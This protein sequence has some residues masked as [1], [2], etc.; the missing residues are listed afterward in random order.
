MQRK[1]G[2]INDNEKSPGG[3]H[4]GLA[5]WLDASDSNSISTASCS[6]SVVSPL[7]SE[8]V[9]CWLD[10]SGRENNLTASGT[11]T[12]K[13]SQFN[14]REAVL[15][16]GGAT[17]LSDMVGLSGGDKDFTV[18]V[19]FDKS[20][21]ASTAV[22]IEFGNASASAG[23]KW[24]L[25]T[26]ADG[27]IS[28][29][30]NVAQTTTSDTPVDI[31]NKPY[32]VSMNYAGGGMQ[33]S[34]NQEIYINGTKK[35]SLTVSGSSSAAASL[36]TRPD[37]SIGRDLTGSSPHQGHI[38]EVVVYDR[39][40][41]DFERQAVEAYLSQKWLEEYYSYQS[42]SELE[43]AVGT[44]GPY[45]IDKDGYNGPYEPQDCKLENVA[46]FTSAT[47]S[48]S[49]ANHSSIQVD[50]SQ[51]GSFSASLWFKV[52]A[53]P[54]AQYI[55]FG[56]GISGANTGKFLV[57]FW[58]DGYLRLAIAE[59]DV[60]WSAIDTESS[61]NFRIT[62]LNRWYHVTAVKDGTNMKIYVD[63]VERASGTQT[64][65]PIAS[66]GPLVVGSDPDNITNLVFKGYLDEV[67]VW[68]K[69]LSSE[70]IWQ[71]QSTAIDPNATDLG[72]LYNFNSGSLLIDSTSNGND[73]TTTGTS[74]SEGPALRE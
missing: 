20:S 63:G 26:L 70:E 34:A 48:M 24:G 71:M 7:D 9:S 67:A 42:C 40:L 6:D 58:P 28:N 16:N 62:D 61:T 10:K 27:N 43:A 44:G 32:V 66:T 73:L 64:N 46:N 72:A 39:K 51:T 55:M 35:H 49:A 65:N 33:S 68:K 23:E 25:E 4:N 52:N 22:P 12:Y 13:T 21:S 36:P 37:I 53:F 50:L 29:A 38:A 47:Q 2:K 56:N 1:W 19:V 59:H 30:W 74:I 17:S 8:S 45:T 57:E 69:A 14:G 15:F 5:L 41:S 31:L 18:F 54:S 60:G 3:V 11:V